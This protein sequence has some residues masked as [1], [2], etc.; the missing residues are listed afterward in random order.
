M[1][2]YGVYWDKQKNPHC[3]SCKKPILDT[4][5]ISFMAKATTASHATR[6][7]HSPTLRGNKIEPAQA[8]SEL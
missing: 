3:P 2:K 8:L 5:P 7:F 4:T 1:P 6:S